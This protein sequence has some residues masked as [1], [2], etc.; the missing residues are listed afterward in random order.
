MDLIPIVELSVAE[1]HDIL[2]S[3]FKVEDLPSLAAVENEDWGRDYLLT[4]LFELSREQLAG[5]GL[6]PDDWAESD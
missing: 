6:T 3:H 4:K 2:S 5:A 1:A